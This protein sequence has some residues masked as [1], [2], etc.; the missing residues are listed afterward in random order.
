MNDIIAN[1]IIYIQLCK[2]N[3]SVFIYQIL[4]K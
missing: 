1:M 3:N 4:K 2:L